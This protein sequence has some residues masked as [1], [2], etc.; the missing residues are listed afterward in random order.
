M[1]IVFHDHHATVPN[2]TRA[3]ATASAVKCGAR[4]GPGVHAVIRFEEDGPLR[5]AEIILHAR[6]KKL[7]AKSAARSYDTA[8]TA[9]V[10]KLERQIHT[11]R[12]L[13]RSRAQLARRTARA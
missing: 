8:L 13:R 4:L 7:V 9:A 3:R 11:E 12:R 2:R 1:E 5:R 10:Q 6:Q